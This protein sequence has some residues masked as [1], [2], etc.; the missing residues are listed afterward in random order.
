MTGEMADRYRELV[1]GGQL[2]HLEYVVTEEN[3]AL[4]RNAVEYP[5][6]GFPSI[7][8]KEPLHVLTRKYGRLPLR[9]INHQERYFSPPRLNRRVQVTGWI[10]GKYHHDGQNWLEVETYAVDEVGTEILR[11][12]HTFLVGEPRSERVTQEESSP[13]VGAP[14]PSVAKRVHQENIDEFR[15]VGRLLLFRFGPQPPPDQSNTNG[16]P[17]RLDGLDR[18]RAPNQMG[19]AYLHEILARRFG[20]DFQQGG[21]LSVTFLGSAYASDRITAHGLII[22]EDTVEHRARLTLRVWL[23]NQRGELTASGEAQVTVPSPLT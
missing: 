1:A 17:N 9:G 20:P 11:S 7:A 21:Q 23:E 22:N 18:S 3:L 19:F 14:L 4:F 10:R 8:L 2:G 12:R 15:G 16:E 5:D 6:A 13:K